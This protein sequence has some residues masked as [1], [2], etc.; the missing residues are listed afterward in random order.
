MENSILPFDVLKLQLDIRTDA[1]L[2]EATMFLAKVEQHFPEALHNMGSCGVCGTLFVLG[3][4]VIY[5]GVVNNAV[6]RTQDNPSGQAWGVLAI[7]TLKCVI[8]GVHVEGTA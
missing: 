6:P 4:G 7:C 1:A 3:S 8:R 2:R 5:E